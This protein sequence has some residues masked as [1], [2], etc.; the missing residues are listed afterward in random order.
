[1][2]ALEQFN[3]DS[4]R[5]NALMA[6]KPLSEDTAT[7]QVV[8]TAGMHHDKVRK[9]LMQDKTVAS[10]IQSSSEKGNHEW[11]MATSRFVPTHQFTL[12]ILPRFNMPHPKSPPYIQGV[13]GVKLPSM[14]QQLCNTFHRA[15]NCPGINA[16]TKHNALVRYL[17]ELCLKGGIPAEREPRQFT[18][19]KC[20]ACSETVVENRKPE[21]MKKCTPDGYHSQGKGLAVGHSSPHRRTWAMHSTRGVSNLVSMAVGGG[22]IRRNS[23]MS[24]GR[25]QTPSES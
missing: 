3:L 6:P 15:R 21:H 25:M 7:G 14:H 22:C 8:V 10:T 24:L 12:A 16:T 20:S 1:M 17:Y 23:S 13:Q 19:Y 5:A 18:S 9:S 2:F 11:I 4:A